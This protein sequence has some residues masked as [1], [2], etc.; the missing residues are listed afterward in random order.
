MLTV[1]VMFLSPVFW[2]HCLFRVIV[3]IAIMDRGEKLHGANLYS[4]TIKANVVNSVSLFVGISL[5]WG[6]PI[7]GLN[8]TAGVRLRQETSL[9]LWWLC[10]HHR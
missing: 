9:R 4:S 5:L 6:K 8:N 10:I 2:E 7:L 1:L 3:L